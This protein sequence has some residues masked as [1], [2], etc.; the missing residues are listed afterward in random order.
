MHSVQLYT[1]TLTKYGSIFI[2]LLIYP[3]LV[4]K[5]IKT[6]KWLVWTEFHNTPSSYCFW[7]NNGLEANLSVLKFQTQ[8]LYLN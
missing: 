3:I 5:P 7:A 1:D 8:I 6:C 4:S 2:K